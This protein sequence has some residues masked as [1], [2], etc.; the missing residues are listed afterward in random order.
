MCVSNP[1]P[2]PKIQHQKQNSALRVLKT[3]DQQGERLSWF[4]RSGQ[5]SHTV[6]Q[7]LSSATLISAA[8]QSVNL[9]AIFPQPTLFASTLVSCYCGLF[10]KLPK[11]FLVLHPM[12]VQTMSP[13][14]IIP[15]LLC[16]TLLMRGEST[17]LQIQAQLSEDTWTQTSVVDSQKIKL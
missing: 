4:S 14:S 8:L 1:H 15:F 6:T 16:K 5:M 17:Q 10:P 2:Q 11:W 9:M 13:Y 12:I 7:C 3:K